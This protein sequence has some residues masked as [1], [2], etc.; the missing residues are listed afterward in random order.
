MSALH[1]DPLE[2][3]ISDIV[4][5][6]KDIRKQLGTIARSLHSEKGQSQVLMAQSYLDLAATSLKTA[7]EHIHKR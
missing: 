4:N 7:K 3:H 6:P 2:I 5:K 1:G